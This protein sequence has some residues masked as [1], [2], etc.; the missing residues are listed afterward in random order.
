GRARQTGW[1]FTSVARA[2]ELHSRPGGM[3]LRLRAVLSGRRLGSARTAAS[4]LLMEVAPSVAVVVWANE[5]EAEAMKQ[6]GLE[7]AQGL[8]FVCL[9]LSYGCA[10]AGEQS[11]RRAFEQANQPEE[12]SVSVG[13]SDA[14]PAAGSPGAE[15]ARGGRPV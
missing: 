3:K 10:G 15:G 1:P 6:R 5:D 11:A 2:A 4:R 7:L 12:R 8:A 13:A 9:G 14:E